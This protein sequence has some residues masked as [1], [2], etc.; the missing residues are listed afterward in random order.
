MAY[1]RLIVALG[2]V[3]T[4]GGAAIV[5]ANMLDEPGKPAP[6]KAPAAKP[7]ASQPP[8]GKTSEGKPEPTSGFP[9]KVQKRLFASV[10][11]REKQAPQVQVEKWLTNKPEFQ[12]KL[13]LVD[14]WATW[15]GPCR[16][17]IPELERWQQV[18]KD[19]L[20]VIGLSGEK[21]SVVANF[22]KQ[23]PIAYSVAIDTSNRMNRAVGVQGLPHVLIIGTDNVVR[24]QGFPQSGEEQLTEA[25]V[26]RI[27]DAD[28]ARRSTTT[29]VTPAP[30]AGS[31]KPKEEAPKPPQGDPKP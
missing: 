18:F 27:I 29:S 8:T 7:P 23:R 12:N 6:E 22:M 30:G 17:L 11:L 31:E 16:A 14:F 26:R 2:V 28:K 1:T 25:M 10:D 21:E 4:A 9:A 5:S 19:D 24:W 13:V 20:V 3:A 15:C